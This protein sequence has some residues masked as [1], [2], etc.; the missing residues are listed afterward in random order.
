M[1]ARRC[2]PSASAP[3]RRRPLR[4]FSLLEVVAAVAIFAVGMIGVLALFAPA[5]SSLLAM[6]RPL[7][8]KTVRRGFVSGDGTPKSAS[9]GPITRT[10][11]FM[12]RS[13]PAGPGGS[14]RQRSA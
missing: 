11:T 10:S 12:A 2:L 14:L 8:S 7:A 1:R 4:G 5:Q 6:A 3:A 13:K 9:V